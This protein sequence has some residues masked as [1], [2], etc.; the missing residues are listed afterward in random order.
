MCV[1]KAASL[2]PNGRQRH[3]SYSTLVANGDSMKV[4][5]APCDCAVAASSGVAPLPTCASG[6]LSALPLIAIL[7]L[8]SVKMS[9]YTGKFAT[10][11]GA[12]LNMLKWSPSNVCS[13]KSY[14]GATS[15]CHSFI[16]SAVSPSAIS[17]FAAMAMMGQRSA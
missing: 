8:A 9:L 13:V 1:F 3:A 14:G 16:L 15:A 5:T 11:F 4:S 6:S 2:S 7:S 17:P 10:C 12:G